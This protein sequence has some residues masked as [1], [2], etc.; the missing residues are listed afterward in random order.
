LFENKNSTTN[1]NQGFAIQRNAGYGAGIFIRK[2]KQIAKSGFSMFVQGA[3]DV[4]YNSNKYE[5]SSGNTFFD[6]SKNYSLAISAYPGISYTISKK[7]QLQTGFNN[8]LSLGY[9]SEKREI[10][11]TSNDYSLKTK[12]INVNTSLNNFSSL[13]LGFRLLISKS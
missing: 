1:P 7:L 4:N 8:L 13:Y 3:F 6:K 9:F 11:G 12:G 2:Y 10:T 5:S